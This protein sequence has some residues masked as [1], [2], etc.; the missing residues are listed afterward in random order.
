MFFPASVRWDSPALVA[1]SPLISRASSLQSFADVGANVS[2]FDD[3]PECL[4][5]N[6]TGHHRSNVSYVH[7]SVERYLCHLRERE[8]SEDNG[9]TSG[10]GYLHDEKIREQLIKPYRR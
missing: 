2:L 7:L 6:R 10:I 3:E 8:H 1:P 5:R 4:L 9:K